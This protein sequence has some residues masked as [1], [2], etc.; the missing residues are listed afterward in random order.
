MTILP[1][2]DSLPTDFTPKVA[3]AIRARA[4]GR[5]EGCHRYTETQLHHRLYKSRGGKGT[6][7]NGIAL[8]GLGGVQ[9]AGMCHGKAHTAEGEELGW[10]LPSNCDPLVMPIRLWRKGRWGIEH[11][12]WALFDNQGGVHWITDEEAARRM[13]GLVA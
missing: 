4:D 13:N 6:V 1:K 8:C 7:A 5:C 9:G 2:T 12:E 3:A 11:R 10:S